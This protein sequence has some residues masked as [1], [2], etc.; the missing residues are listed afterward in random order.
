[1]LITSVIACPFCGI[2][3]LEEMPTETAQ[4]TYP[5]HSCSALLKVVEDECCVFCSFGDIPCPRAQE[6]WEQGDGDCPKKPQPRT[7]GASR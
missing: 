3:T 1:M 5:C 4:R 7:R 2:S 6:D